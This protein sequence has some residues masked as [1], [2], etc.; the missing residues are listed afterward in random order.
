MG[1]KVSA[2]PSGDLK[3]LI[4]EIDQPRIKAVVYFFSIEFERFEPHKALKRA[5][6]QAA[7]I[8]MSMSGGWCTAGAVEKGLVAMSFSEDE[9]EAVFTSLKENAASDSAGAAKD[10]IADLKR[11]LGRGPIN[12]N[13]Y[14]GIVLFS[15]PCRGEEIMKAFTTEK[16]LNLPFIGG[17]AG[18]ELTFTKTL[19]A[20]DEK[21]SA[22][23]LGVMVLK[24]KIPFFCNHYVHCVPT[25]TAVT[26]T[27]AD[28]VTRT[29]WEIDGQGA[30]PYYAKLIGLPNVETLKPGDFAAHPMGIVVGD[31][32]YVRSINTLAEGNIG[33]ACACE[34]EPHTKVHILKLGD[35]IDNARKAVLDAG[36]FTPNLQGAILFN[37]VG[38][39][40]ELKQLG[41]TA[42]FNDAFKQL[43]FIGCNTYGE[44]LF[45][46][47]N[48]TLTAVFFGR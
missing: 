33:L 18:D 17:V 25:N 34:L 42:V 16:D 20:V 12:P 11:K 5:F 21:Q 26:I 38:R 30:A 37:C 1:I 35:I 47:H 10:V 27:K 45:T 14:L 32:V 6:P 36:S 22:E 29:V 43:S 13:A 2:S 7:C 40:L 28:T 8:G 46:H 24:M 41:K 4:Q 31:Q 15:F 23:G 44:E 19:V 9:V 48:Q 39:Y 3:K